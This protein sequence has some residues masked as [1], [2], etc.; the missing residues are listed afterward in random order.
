MVFRSIP[1]E[2]GQEPQVSERG[3]LTLSTPYG[4]LVAYRSSGTGWRWSGV[5][6]VSA[7]AREEFPWVDWRKAR[8]LGTRYRSPEQVLENWEADLLELVEKEA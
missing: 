5:L 4:R 2:R 3:N 6:Y 8:Y 1:M 7:R